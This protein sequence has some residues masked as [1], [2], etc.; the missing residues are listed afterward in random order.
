MQTPTTT[1]TDYFRFIDLGFC[2]SKQLS[3]HDTPIYVNSFGFL[4]KF[5]FK[6][7]KVTRVG[8]NRSL[9]HLIAAMEHLIEVRASQEGVRFKDKQKLNLFKNKIRVMFMSSEST[10]PMTYGMIQR[11]NTALRPVLDQL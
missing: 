9:D 10:T 6:K 5:S 4:E 2:Q 7:A 11:I 1:S 3:A 8:L